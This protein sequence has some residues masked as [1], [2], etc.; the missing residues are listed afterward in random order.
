M[1]NYEWLNVRLQIRHN[2]EA[3]L[4][5]RARQITCLS[6]EN[7]VENMRLIVKSYHELMDTAKA[8]EQAARTLHLVLTAAS[9]ISKLGHVKSRAMNA[10][11]MEAKLDL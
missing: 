6:E 4:S 11:V 3:L 10:L 9:K 1:H 5:K 7:D 2:Q 8:I